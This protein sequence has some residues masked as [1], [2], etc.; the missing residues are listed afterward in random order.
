V[1][2]FQ[3][4]SVNN[5]RDDVALSMKCELMKRMSLH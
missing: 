2:C 5:K 1:E 3:D 4:G